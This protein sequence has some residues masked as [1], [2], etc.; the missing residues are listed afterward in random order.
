MSLPT[1]CDGPS[2]T[3]VAINLKKVI[4]TRSARRAHYR[5]GSASRNPLG[6]DEVND[7]DSS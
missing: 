2:A 7:H 3:S 1:L 5:H 4:L 6:V